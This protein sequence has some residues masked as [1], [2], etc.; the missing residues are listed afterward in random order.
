M[1]KKQR[2]FN[3]RI[4][5]P[6]VA[7]FTQTFLGQNVL[8]LTYLLLWLILFWDTSTLFLLTIVIYF[9][10]T[11]YLIQLTFVTLCINGLYDLCIHNSYCGANILLSFILLFVFSSVYS[12]F[13]SNYLKINNAHWQKNFLLF[14]KWQ[15]LIFPFLFFKSDYE[16]YLY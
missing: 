14:S 15:S 6:T 7:F 16:Y 8:F 9:A 10:S 12:Y 4:F 5:S 3:P 1:L 11:G 2:T 13:F